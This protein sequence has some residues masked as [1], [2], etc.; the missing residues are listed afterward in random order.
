MAGKSGPPTCDGLAVDAVAHAGHVAVGGQAQP[1]VK[2]PAGEGGARC[3]GVGELE[4]QARRAGG[5]SGRHLS[6]PST[7]QARLRFLSLPVPHLYTS[8]EALHIRRRRTR[9]AASRKTMI[10]PNLPPLLPPSL[11]LVALLLVLLLLPALTVALA[12]VPAIAATGCG[13]SAA[14]TV[15]SALARSAAGLVAAPAAAAGVATIAATSA[16]ASS[17]AAKL[18][19]LPLRLLA[20]HRRLPPLVEEVSGAAAMS[21]SW[22]APAQARGWRGTA[23]R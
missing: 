18:G 15:S 13:P 14:A 9:V 17:S 6:G 10:I 1:A 7:T 22:T 4:R 2:Q 16:T 5:K 11:L 3:A 12:G 23:R 8:G 21:G 20:L 19:R